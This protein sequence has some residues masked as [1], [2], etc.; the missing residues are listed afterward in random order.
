MLLIRV[1]LICILLMGLISCGGNDSI[2]LPGFDTEA[3]TAPTNLAARAVSSSEINLTWTA[4]TDNT[5]VVAYSIYRKE[6]SSDHHDYQAS[7][8]VEV[9][10]SH[11]DYHDEGLE[12]NREYC[13]RIYA[14]DLAANRSD[15]SNEACATTH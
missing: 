1:G 12:G 11:S 5:G 13:Y 2:A 15:R 14:I 9:I 4:S 7:D 3:P 10:G 6:G 8:L